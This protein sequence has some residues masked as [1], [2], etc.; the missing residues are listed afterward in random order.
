VT[1]LF[2]GDAPTGGGRLS[3]VIE[4][5]LHSG[6]S[7]HGHEFS[8][9]NT[10]TAR[11][12]PL[13]RSAFS[14][15][16]PRLSTHDSTSPA[17]ARPAR[18]LSADHRKTSE[19]VSFSELEVEITSDDG[20]SYASEGSEATAGG[21]K[22]K[23]R[24]STRSSTSYQLAHPAP[25]LTRQQR[26]LHIRP[27]LLL[28]LQRFSSDKRPLPCIDVLPSIVVVPRLMKRFPRMFKG[29]GE[30]GAND[31]L[32][33]KSED[34]DTP[35]DGNDG[36]LGDDESCANREVLAV[37]C[38]LRGLPGSAEIC[39]GDGSVWYA[40]PMPKGVFEF[41]TTDPITGERTVAR[42]VQR[43]SP[44]R[45]SS[46]PTTPA[47]GSSVPGDYKYL[48]S[49]LHPNSRR[50]PI[51]ASITQRILDIPDN[52]TTVS[53]SAGRYPPTSPV[54]GSIAGW[55]PVPEEEDNLERTTL[56]IDDN[57]RT[58]I[59][60]TGLWL[61]LRLGWCP[62]F[63]YDD[64]PA[65]TAT[66][67]VS[68]SLPTSASRS[69]ST[70][71]ANDPYKGPVV[72]TRASTPESYPGSRNPA[73]GKIFRS[74]NHIFRS[75]PAST[76]PTS[77]DHTA[78]IPRRAVSTGTA[79]M[80]RAAARRAGHLPSTVV[81]D[82]EGELGPSSMRAATSDVAM[83]LSDRKSM[84]LPPTNFDPLA[85]APETP[86]RPFHRRVQSVFMPSSPLHRSPPNGVN[87][88]ANGN[89]KG[90]YD[91]TGQNLGGMQQRGGKKGG[92]WNALIRFLRRG[93]QS[94]R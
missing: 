67:S 94:A 85:N 36:D 79:F 77:F 20:F 63:K 40:T 43:V 54:R 11:R 49:I 41:V 86:T 28:Q 45:H 87:G 70:S 73:G 71:V 62:Y 6:A 58:L 61:A 65:L 17:I 24:K 26:L 25:T 59:Q 8:P 30:L 35:D 37:I 64:I 2:A 16:S 92:R 38:P 44:R 19:Q 29:K 52:Y 69:C 14:V 56:P 47:A 91:G 84:P 32:V 83:N 22:K 76:S 34:Y 23:K 80:Q 1:S 89:P 72:D 90:S 93:E 13:V 78:P 82:S 53:S 60:V 81:S 10:P 50:H 42:W 12:S 55:Q 9:I 7:L 31:V 75:S 18:R 66:K 4:M 48:F 39:L 46:L 57:T 21:T 51:L 74:G 15:P 3:S 68:P 27:K 33:V 88:H 5:F